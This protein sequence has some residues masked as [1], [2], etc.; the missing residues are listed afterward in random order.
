VGTRA[1]FAAALAFALA[2]PFAAYAR[3]AWDVMPGAA[4][5]CGMLAAA[6]ALLRGR[7]PA[8][9]ALLCAAA[10][11]LA[12]TFRF[13]LLPFF[14]PATLVVFAIA[15]QQRRLTPR[16]AVLAG[17]LLVALLAPSFVYNF[18][19]TGSPLRPATAAPQYLNHQNALNGPMLVG[20]TGLLVSPNRGLFVF[21][22]LLLLSIA[23]PWAWRRLA[24]AQRVVLSSYGAAAAAHTLLMAKIVS[25]DV[26][27]WGPRYMV[28]VLPVVFF[29]AACVAMTIA[30][31]PVPRRI[32]IALAACALL[33]SLPAMIVDWPQVT[34]AAQ[35]AWRPTQIPVAWGALLHGVS[36][37]YPDWFLW[38]L[39]QLSPAS[40]VAAASAAL[41]AVASMT[42]TGSRIWRIAS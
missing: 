26:F 39:A 18:V 2:T 22:P 28:P 14:G 3:T 25:W 8:R 30:D 19:R 36:P 11:A 24:G 1:A 10:L 42:F 41:A 17:V 6:D 13:S 5:L 29:A 38:R 16:A 9:S 15:V 34:A 7:A 23:A 35:D 21:S 40:A 4:F 32:A 37:V 33:V 12:C 20:L 31:R 27:G